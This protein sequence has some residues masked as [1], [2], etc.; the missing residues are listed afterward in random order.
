MSNR[1]LNIFGLARGA[2]S[3]V[4]PSKRLILY[5]SNGYTTNQDGQRI[6][7]Y[8]K[9]CGICGSVQALQYTDILK[10]EGLNLQGER[11]K[12]YLYGNID[13]LVRVDNKGG[14]ILVTL[15]RDGKPDGR[16]WL[17]ATV[18]EYWPDWCSVAV[19]L[20]NEKFPLP[21][22]PLPSEAQ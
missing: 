6:P 8:L 22:G 4:L 19:T 1:G 3:A 9:P 5:I 12:I 2:A 15:K 14:D 16:I 20:Q 21:C 17:V 18:L 11:R 13:G 7:S 10:L